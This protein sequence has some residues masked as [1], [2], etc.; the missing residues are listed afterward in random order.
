MCIPKVEFHA[1]NYTDPL[2]V[3]VS[4]AVLYIVDFSFDVATMRRLIARARRV[5]LIDHH[6]RTEGIIEELRDT[7][8]PG[9]FFGIFN[10]QMSGALLTW[11][12]FRHDSTHRTPKHWGDQPPQILNHISDRDLWLF[13]LPDTK[14]ICDGLS[15]YPKSPEAWLN[16][17]VDGTF[18]LDQMKVDA[19]PVRRLKNTIIDEIVLQTLRMVI[20]SGYEVPLIN[21]PRFLTSDALATLTADY[22]FAVAYYDSPEGRVFSLRSDKVKGI[23]I[24]SICQAM[25]G[26]G[27]DHAGGFTAPSDHPLAQL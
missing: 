19:N 9:K 24:R 8:P 3:D 26:D 11:E 4:N 22:P 13:K 25:N 20:M 5:I 14:V 17:P 23:N 16:L 7:T 21:C 6:P 18:F 27:H 1:L 15:Q 10:S 2:P 12:Y